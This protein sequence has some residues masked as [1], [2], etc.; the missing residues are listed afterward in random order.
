MAVF[1]SLYPY[2]MPAVQGCPSAIADS[3]IR[4]ALIEFCE[5]TNMWKH[6][7]NPINIVA[8]QD[9]YTFTLPTGAAMSKPT[10]VAVS[11]QFVSPTN[12]EDLDLLYASWRDTTSKQP[13][14][15]YMD[16]DGSMILVPTPSD[17]I[18]GGLKVEAALRPAIDSTTFPDWILENWAEVIA[19]GALMRL[20]AMPGKVW[21]DTKTVAFHRAKFRDGITRAKS[22]TMK[23]FS[24]QGKSVQPRQFWE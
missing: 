11:G 1:S 16:Y 9:V 23:S 2:V 14:M 6:S 20:H 19:H 10:Y 18:T 15:Y 21:S 3:A 5:K 8:D 17:S 13:I 7:F 24:R 22:R 4:L 12:E